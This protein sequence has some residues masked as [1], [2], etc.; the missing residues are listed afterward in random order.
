ML[1]KKILYCYLLG[2]ATASAIATDQ[3]TT[4]T[5]LEIEGNMK[6]TQS[7]KESDLIATA[8]TSEQPL[9]N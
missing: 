2:V 7:L 5:E 4:L 3:S 1:T 9:T 8:T 6:P